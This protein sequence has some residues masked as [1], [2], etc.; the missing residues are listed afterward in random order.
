MIK[1]RISKNQRN[2]TK[3]IVYLGAEVV[4]AKLVDKK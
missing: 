1:F 2:Q 3:T 4:V